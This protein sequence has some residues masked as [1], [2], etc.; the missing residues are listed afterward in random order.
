MQLIKVICY[1]ILMYIYLIVIIRIM[2]KK[3]GG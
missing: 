1:T 2:G 3:R